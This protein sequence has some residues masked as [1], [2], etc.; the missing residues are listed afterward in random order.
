[1]QA[2]KTELKLS[3]KISMSAA[4]LAISVPEIPSRKANVSLLDSWRV[5]GSFADH[6]DHTAYLLQSHYQQQH[7]FRP[8][9]G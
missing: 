7:V 9:S 1:M 5:V 3:S 8:R 4:S 2:L 6:C